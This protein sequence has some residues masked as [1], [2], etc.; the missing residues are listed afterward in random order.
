MSTP[1]ATWLAT[2]GH[3]LRSLQ[4]D[5]GLPFR[6][7]VRYEGDVTTWSLSGAI[8]AAPDAEPELLT[9]TVS[10]PSLVDGFTQW[11]LTLTGTQTKNL[12]ADDTGEGLATFVF[13]V[14]IA[15]T[16]G[17]N[18]RRLFGGLFNVSGFVTE[19]A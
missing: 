15:E 17:A 1:F 16:A 6:H 9:F 4:V 5:R 2:L 7:L 11:E 18:P 19:I 14:L 13:D 12:P 10:S 3:R 8:K